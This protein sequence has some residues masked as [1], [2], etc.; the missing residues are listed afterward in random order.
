V[1]SSYKSGIKWGVAA[2]IVMHVCSAPEGPVVI[3]GILASYCLVGSAVTW[4]RT[5][6]ALRTLS[7][8]TLAGACVA[9]TVWNQTNGWEFSWTSSWQWITAAVF[10]VSHACDV[11]EARLQPE[12]RG[13]YMQPGRN[14]TLADALMF[15]TIPRLENRNGRLHRVGA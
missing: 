10:A 9:G 13:L 3:L 8:A 4:I 6:L 11:L 14:D 1:G 15:R 12:V 7:L 2:Y 5:H